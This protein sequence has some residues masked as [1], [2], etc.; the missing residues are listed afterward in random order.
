MRLTRGISPLEKIESWLI[1]E[2][3]MQTLINLQEPH[4]CGG[5]QLMIEKGKLAV[6]DVT[7]R[8]S[9]PYALAQTRYFHQEHTPQAQK[10]QG[11]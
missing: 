4:I 3:T 1:R 6:K 10:A 7:K 11:K 5:C 8:R 9:G 2:K